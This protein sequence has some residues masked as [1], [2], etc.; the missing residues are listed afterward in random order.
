MSEKYTLVA[1]LSTLLAIVS[2]VVIGAIMATRGQ[3]A[4]ALGIGGA[5]IGL[6][7]LIGTFKPTTRPPENQNVTV[8]NQPEQPVP[9][10]EGE[11]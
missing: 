11:K 9:T 5:V 3:D 4:E 8:T 6:I 10:T 1:F 7:G 2:L